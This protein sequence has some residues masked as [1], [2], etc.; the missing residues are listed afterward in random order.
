MLA[1]SFWIWIRGD[2]FLAELSVL[3]VPVVPCCVPTPKSLFFLLFHLKT[4]QL[5]K[6]TY[7]KMKGLTGGI[8]LAVLA[9]TA[10][11]QGGI[12]KGPHG[13]DT[14]NAANIGIENSASNTANQDI[15]DDHSQSWKGPGPWY[16][17]P[18]W[19]PPPPG[20]KRDD[21]NE[22]PAGDDTGNTA[23]IG[24][25]NEAESETTQ[26]IED[27]HSKSWEGHGH[28]G[29][30]WWKRDDINEG[31]TGDDTGNV[32]NI[33]IENEAE[34]ETNQAI[35]D[36]HSK[37][38]EG[39]GHPGWPWWKRDDINQGPTGDDTGNAATIGLEN[40]AESETTQHIKDDHSWKAKGWPYWYPGA[41][42]PYPYRQPNHGANRPARGYH[43]GMKEARHVIGDIDEGP[44]GDDIG[45]VAYI[46]IKNEA[47][48]KYKGSYKD[49]HAV[50][51][52]YA[53]PWHQKR[54]FAPSTGSNEDDE[55]SQHSPSITNNEMSYP[56]PDTHAANQEACQ[57][58]EVTRT[59]TMTRTHTAMATETAVAVEDPQ[60]ATGTSL[61]AVQ[62]PAA[63][64]AVQSEYP[65]QAVQNPNLHS[66]MASNAVPMASS[67]A[68]GSQAPAPEPTPVAYHAPAASQLTVGQASAYT[69]I[70]VY[71]PG[72]AAHGSVVIQASSTPASSAAFR[73]HARPTGASPEQNARSSSSASASASPSSSHGPVSFTGAAGKL[74]PSAGVFT[75]LAGAAALVAFA[76]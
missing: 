25:E 47:S 74:A 41:P 15:K 12:Y 30:P 14:G 37:S 55:G 17:H 71:V 76:L 26:H 35:E 19:A 59:V 4:L 46:P 68:H 70:P 56:A 23:T 11:A 39:H 36:D 42:Y 69:V 48:N 1:E 10:H 5:Q 8:P 53:W 7:K 16:G 27:D 65:S 50:D 45:N 29:W 75:V 73:T 33:G 60:E 63:T 3:V 43:T 32:A 54:A 67:V 62:T 40:E 21:I 18:Y 34:F 57:A 6:T 22:G 44:H 38:W 61:H 2:S 51:I 20:W 9:A 28:P 31:P 13:D 72:S 58:Q 66:G 52:D 49:N 24:I 64:Q